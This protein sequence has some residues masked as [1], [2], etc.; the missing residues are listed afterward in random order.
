MASVE[1][2]APDR[3]DLKGAERMSGVP[4]AWRLAGVAVLVLVLIL[5]PVFADSL[6]LGKLS[7]ILVLST[8]V[9]GVNLATG[10]GGLISLGHGAFMAFG[11]FFSVYALDDLGLPFPL[12][13]VASF[14]ATTA[15]GCVLGLPGL[16]IRGIHLALVTFGLAVLVQPMAKQLPRFTGGGVGKPVEYQVLAPPWF[17]FTDKDDALFRYI[18]CVIICA[19][20]FLLTHNLINS[21][22]G[23]SIRAMRDGEQSAAVY[24]VNLTITKVL[25]FGISAGLAGLAG[26]MQAILFPFV[27]Q[28]DYGVVDSLTLYAAAVIGGLGSL[29]GTLLGVAALVIVPAAN[30]ALGLLDNAALVFGIALVAF[31]FVFPGGLIEVVRDLASRDPKSY[32]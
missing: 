18:V 3:I 28:E 23:R 2:P 29:A 4:T 17:D 21:R 19:C 12:A 11:A 10:Y 6:G 1:S 27:S 22:I 30:D 20:A 15:F 32:D 24:G 25:T 31:T 5:L 8:A 26:A 14:L 13:M 7:R 16:R 9:L